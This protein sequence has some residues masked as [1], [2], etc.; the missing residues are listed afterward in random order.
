[1]TQTSPTVV[2]A[3][4][5]APRRKQPPPVCAWLGNRLHAAENHRLS[6]EHWVLHRLHCPT[7]NQADPKVVS[8]R[9]FAI[10]E[11]GF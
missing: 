10:R 4:T 1:M 11:V 8:F 6:V 7:L 5:R 2:D 3:T 9:H